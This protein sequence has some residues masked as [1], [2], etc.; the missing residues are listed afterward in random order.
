MAVLLCAAGVMSAGFDGLA[1]ARPLVPAENRYDSYSGRL[2]A[3]GDPSVFERIQSRFHDRESEFW[4]SGLEILGFSDVRE[5]GMRSNGLDYIPRRY[6]VARAAF[7]NQSV[8]TVAYSIVEDQ[9]IIGFGFGVDWCIAGLDRN[10]AN[11]PD[12]R[13]AGP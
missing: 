3:C 12:C 5:V 7:N 1:Q 2:P 13:M 6:C 9:G 4:K 10:Y 11:A 8:R